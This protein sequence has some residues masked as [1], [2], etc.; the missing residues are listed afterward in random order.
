MERL[1][2]TVDELAKA[3][4][5]T[6]R[7]VWRD[8]QRGLLPQPLPARLGS[9]HWHVADAEPWMAWRQGRQVDKRRLAGLQRHQRTAALPEDASV[10]ELAAMLDIS[11]RAIWRLVA[12]G[13]FPK[14]MPK[15][16]RPR[17]W[18][19]ADVVAWANRRKAENSQ[20]AGQV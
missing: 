10:E 11:E 16:L 4:G 8:V 13:D 6:T 17:L 7:T 18:R 20:Q 2:I 3:G 12:S 15:P 9:A 14:P 1:L 5:V 19:T